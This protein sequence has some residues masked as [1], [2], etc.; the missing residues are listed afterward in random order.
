MMLVI[1][2]SALVDVLTLDPADCP[3]LVKRVRDTEWMSAPDLLDYEVLNVLRKMVARDVIDAELAESSRLMLGRL[4]LSRHSM[5]EALSERIWELRGNA[6][7]YNASY[8]ALAE[9]LGVPLVTTDNRLARGLRPHTSIDI[10][11]YAPG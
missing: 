4:R 5:T 9:Q 11:S 1:D 7:A 2:A 8:V 3:D 6:S 10:D